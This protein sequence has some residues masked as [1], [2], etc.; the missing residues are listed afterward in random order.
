MP[1]KFTTVQTK[2][3][4][5]LLVILSLGFYS[6]FYRGPFESWVNDSLAGVFYEIFWC[7]FLYLFLSSSKPYK[8]AIGVL[9]C[10]SM[11]ELLQLWQSPILEHVRST[12][13]GRTLLGT[14]FSSTDFIYY[15]IGCFLGWLWLQ[16]ISRKQEK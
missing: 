10:T 15:I 11:L 8:I 9:F 3:I 13:L 1:S 2:I 4:L 16:N 7:L 14:T 12:F 6:K 5:S